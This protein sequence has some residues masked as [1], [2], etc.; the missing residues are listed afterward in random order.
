MTD[1]VAPATPPVT[2]A[3]TPPKEALLRTAWPAVTRMPAVATLGRLLLKPVV[4]APLAGLLLAPLY[5]GKAVPGI[6]RR[7]VLTTR[8][9]MVQG[10]L[11]W[12]PV[13]EIALADIDEV[14]VRTDANSAFYGA[15]HLDLVSNG[16]VKLS[17]PGV[18]GAEA[19]RQAIL[20]ACMAWVPG[21]ASQWVK[22][23]PARPQK[24]G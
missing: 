16:A 14:V 17:L 13:Q 1:A 11:L 21:R 9:V 5:F 6:G 20:N 15:A 8:R 23:I 18:S 10:G 12:R 24:A 2:Q 3:A 19:F 7:Y 22:F 4:T